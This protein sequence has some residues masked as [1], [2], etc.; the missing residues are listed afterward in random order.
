[1]KNWTPQEYSWRISC[2]NTSNS[3]ANNS[4]GIK[5]RKFIGGEIESKEVKKVI[6]IH[7]LPIQER[8][9]RLTH[10][11]DLDKHNTHA[12]PNEEWRQQK[13]SI[14]ATIKMIQ[15]MCVWRTKTMKNIWTMHV[16]FL[17]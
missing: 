17:D 4:I 15:E 1:L 2:G 8:K 11:E 9:E 7:F 14:M 16:C 6:E 13:R 10:E 5:F 12:T 3:R